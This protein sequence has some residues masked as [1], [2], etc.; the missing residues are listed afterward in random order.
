MFQR[1]LLFLSII[2]LGLSFF[3]QVCDGLGI[4]CRG[5]SSC[6]AVDGTLRDITDLV[7]N[8]PFGR[9]AKRRYNHN[10]RIAQVCDRFTGGLAVF[11][12]D[13][14]STIT[15]MQACVL[16]RLLMRHGCK[17]CGSIPLDFPNSNDVKKGQLTVNYVFKC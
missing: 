14:R 15:P 1:K 4:N 12:Q 8:F 9:N 16:L 3:P 13:T 6:G 11:T 2:L 17:A 7:C 5:S 10:E